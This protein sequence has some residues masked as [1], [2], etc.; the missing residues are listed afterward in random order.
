M[1]GAP[2]FHDVSSDLVDSYLLFLRGRGPEPDTSSLSADQ[3]RRLHEQFAIVAALADRAPALPAFD[4]D[5]V[6][7]RLGLA[8]PGEP[9]EAEAG[10]TAEDPVES[11][12][13]RL[14]LRFDRQVAVDYAPAWSQWRSPGMSAVAQCSALGNSVALFTTPQARLT[15]EPAEVAVFLRQYPD[16]S[17]VCLSTLDARQAVLLTPADA[18]VSLDPVRGWLEPGIH[19]PADL[20]E[21]TLGRYFEARLPRWDRVA[22]FTELIDLGDVRADAV[23]VATTTLA[24]ARRTRPRLAHKR[25]ALT[26][27]KAIDSASIGDVVAEVQAGRLSGDA[28]IGRLA[29]LAGAAS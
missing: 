18:T 17:A 21:V 2:D 4:E 10:D 5:P 14:E 27:L 1:D 12:L 28:L 16:I 15:D 8:R 7:I 20:L 26:A 3:R 24:Q 9:T 6:A 19:S 13:R 25:A 11:A 23:A 22:A 29:A